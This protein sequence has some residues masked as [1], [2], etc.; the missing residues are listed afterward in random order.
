M[1]YELETKNLG[2]VPEFG[3]WGPDT[4]KIMLGE[5]HGISTPQF[6]RYATDAI[7]TALSLADGVQEEK[8]IGAIR[9][10]LE[11]ASKINAGK[12]IR[13]TQDPLNFP[14]QQT[15]EVTDE[16]E[17]SDGL[18]FRQISA[19]RSFWEELSKVIESDRESDRNKASQLLEE[20]LLA[21]NLSQGNI[22]DYLE[23][24]FRVEEASIVIGKLYV[25]DPIEFTRFAIHCI[26]GGLRGWDSRG[27]PDYASE[28]LKRLECALI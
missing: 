16:W 28:S 19:P 20:Y 7:I 21:I 6:C 12:K 23:N 27:V 9:G 15:I 24:P 4:T 10:T 13:L 2:K 18:T 17:A 14:R 26:G 22:G 3:F 1:S 11:R 5:L 8:I 25:L